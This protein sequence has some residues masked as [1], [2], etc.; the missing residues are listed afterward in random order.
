MIGLE[1]QRHLGIVIL[2]NLVGMILID[3]SRGRIAIST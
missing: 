2:G 1:S 3:A